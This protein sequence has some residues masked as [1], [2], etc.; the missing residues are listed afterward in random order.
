MMTWVTTNGELHV[1][2]RKSIQKETEKKKFKVEPWQED[3][4]YIICASKED[5][6]ISLNRGL[7]QSMLQ[8]MKPQINRGNYNINL[9]IFHN[10]KIS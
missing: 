10:L 3:I 4:E 5:V 7:L 1:L 6:T 8:Q 2:Q 9:I